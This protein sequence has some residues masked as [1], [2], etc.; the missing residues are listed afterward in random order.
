MIETAWASASTY[1]HTDMR[2]GANGSR[3]RLSP[4]KDWEVNK[5]AQLSKVLD[6]YNQLADKVNASIA[7]LIVLGGNVAIEKASGV[8]VPFTP[9]R[10]DATQ[11]MTDVDSFAVLEPLSDGFRNYEKQDFKVSPEEMLLDKSQL[12]GLTAPEMTVLIGGFRSLGITT[13]RNGIFTNDIN[14]LSNDFFVSLLDMSTEWKPSKNNKSFSGYDR[15][16]GENSKYATR[17]DLIFGSNSQLRAISE[18]YACEDSKELFINDFILAWN[19]VMNADRFD[20]EK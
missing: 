13:E 19:K 14:N 3:I 5:P 9:G 20:L 16:T 11:E 7:D 4:Q 12:L 6:V 1:R 10:G 8:E 15:K 17:V 18:V 2:G